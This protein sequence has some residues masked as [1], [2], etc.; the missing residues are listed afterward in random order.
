MAPIAMAGSEHGPVSWT[1][2]P[3]KGDHLVLRKEVERFAGIQPGL[4]RRPDLHAV[5]ADLFQGPAVCDLRANELGKPG[6]RLGCEDVFREFL[7][8]A[9]PDECHF[10]HRYLLGRGLGESAPAIAKFFLNSVFRVQD[11]VSSFGGD[12]TKGG[13]NCPLWFPRVLPSFQGE[14]SGLSSPS[15]IGTGLA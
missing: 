7:G 13:K 15:G 3:S 5:P 12:N 4:L 9:W 14:S 11:S 2:R 6:Q 8:Q 1:R 10:F